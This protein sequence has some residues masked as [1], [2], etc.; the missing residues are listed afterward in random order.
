MHSIEHIGHIEDMEE[1]KGY[2]KIGTEKGFD[3]YENSNYIPMGFSFD[4]Y[5][6]EEEYAAIDAAAQYKDRILP[7]YLIVSTDDIVKA[8]LCVTHG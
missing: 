7:K 8:E 1:L 4:E 6:T 3:I 5:I 2:S